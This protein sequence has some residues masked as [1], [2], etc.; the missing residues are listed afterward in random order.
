[1]ESL[2]GEWIIIAINAVLIALIITAPILVGILII[3]LLRKGVS[4]DR[5][6]FEDEIKAEL[7][8]IKKQLDNLSQ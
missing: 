2:W 6:I 4:E 1:M 3:R 8:E 5:R 7:T